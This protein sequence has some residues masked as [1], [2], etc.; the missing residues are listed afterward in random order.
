[1]EARVLASHGDGTFTIKYSDG[2]T[3]D[4]V[5]KACMRAPAERKGRGS[6]KRTSADE[7]KKRTCVEKGC[8]RGDTLSDMT[9]APVDALD[10]YIARDTH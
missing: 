2:Q 4:D 9:V 3:E 5:P 6:S 1:M 10:R 7:D 8:F